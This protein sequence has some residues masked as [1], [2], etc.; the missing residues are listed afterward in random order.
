MWADWAR[1][2]GVPPL[3]LM[4]TLGGI[5]E[6]GS[7][8]REL[9]PLVRPGLDGRTEAAARRAAGEPVDITA[10]DLYPDAIPSLRA[11]VAGGYRVGI[12]GNQPLQAEAVLRAILSAQDLDLDLVAS[13]AGW[14]VAKPDP[15]FFARVVEA[16]GLPAGEIAYVGDRLDNDVRPAAAAGLAAI[17]VRRG[18]WA[19]IQAGRGPVPEARAVID[20]L[21]ELVDVLPG[22]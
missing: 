1:W 16:V 22:I 18:P 10:A 21:V 11:L 2:L 13:S 15:A 8:Q 20:G 17:L 3:T 14:G 9:V 12:A 6:R 7:D 5:I 19:L 4:G